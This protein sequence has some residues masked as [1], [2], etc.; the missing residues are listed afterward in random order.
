MIVTLCER[1]LNFVNVVSVVCL[2]SSVMYLVPVVTNDGKTDQENRKVPFLLS[3][4]ISSGLIIKAST[5]LH[6]H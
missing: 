5:V 4:L 1:L 3:C 2:A 6:C